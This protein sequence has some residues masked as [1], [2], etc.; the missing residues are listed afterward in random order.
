MRYEGII[1]FDSNRGFYFAE[2]SDE[3]RTSVFVHQ[4]QVENERH[5]R[6]NDRIS[7]ELIPSTRYPGKKEAAQVKYLGHL[8]AAQY[9]EGRASMVVNPTEA[10]NV[11]NK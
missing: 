1:V 4:R 9:G 10:Q 7:F 2:T 5:L 11:R 8:V 6:I 3:N